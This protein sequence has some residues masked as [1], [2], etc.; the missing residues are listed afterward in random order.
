MKNKIKLY[1][2]IAMAALIGFGMAGCDSPTGSYGYTP[3]VDRS[4]LSAAIAQAEAR[5]YAT[6]QAADGSGVAATDHWAT[7]EDLEAFADAIA[8]AL[9]VFASPAATQA[10][11]NAALAALS[12]A[13]EDFYEEARQPGEKVNRD[14]LGAATDMAGDLLDATEASADGSDVPANEYWAT[15]DAIAAFAAAID[16]AQAVLDNSAATPEE[17]AAA[18]ANLAEA[19]RAFD[20]A[21]KAGTAV[22][23]AD[24]TVSFN[25]AGGSPTPGNQTVAEGGFAIAPTPAPTRAGYTLDGWFAPGAAAPFAFATTPITANITLAA[26]WTAV[27]TVGG[28]AL[29]VVSPSS[30]HTMAIRDDGSLWAWGDNLHGVLGDGITDTRFNPVRIGD[31][32]D[33]AHISAGQVHTMAI[34]DDGSLWAWGRNMNGRLGDGTATDRDTPVQI[35]DDYDWAYVS[36]GYAHTMAIRDDGSLWAWGNNGSGRLGDGTATT[37][38]LWATNNDRAIPV[39][40]GDDYDW[41][42]VSA[43]YQHTMAIRDDGSLWAWGSN[44]YGQLGDGTYRNDNRSPVRVGDD[45]WA[46]VSAGWRHTMA[47]RGDG[48]L[49]AWGRNMNGR[50]GDG[51]ATDRDTPVQIGDDYDWASVFASDSHT[52]AIRSDGSLWAWGN[53]RGGQLG[54]GYVSGSI[55]IP[56]RVGDAND[57]ASVSA[58]WQHTMAIRGDGSLWAWGENSMGQLGDGTATQRR[59]P[60]RIA[61]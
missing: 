38:G 34:R 33:W 15:A 6:I 32:Y 16:A 41:A 50:L 4:A 57:W 30:H 27:T 21:R 24:F 59:S 49:W 60:V 42:Y 35:G 61:W 53:T 45:Y 28:T 7:E 54:L 36:A 17:I 48:S 58:S 8:A 2:I 10:Q 55:N 39:R 11:V 1:G 31:D 22:A 18:F 19:R 47:I 29:R 25:A 44:W 37:T 9:A 26:R 43:G 3:T 23:A 56:T 14:V 5:L 46:Y 52:M 40:I 20:E 13:H 51:T 12:A